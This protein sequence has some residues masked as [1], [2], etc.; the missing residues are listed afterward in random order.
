MKSIGMIEMSSIAAGFNVADTMLKAG[1]ITLILA[2]S[3]CSGKY[4][5]LIGG[6]TSSVQSSVDAGIAAADGCLIAHFVIAIAFLGAVREPVRNRW[7]FDFG[8]IACGLVVP[9]AL[10][11]GGWRGIPLWWRLVDCS[12]GILGFIPLWFCRGWTLELERIGS[13]TGA[14]S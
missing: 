9:F 5:V 6:E 3:I 2:R 12:F 13:K 1:D 14:P 7:L 10:L 11:V 8:L 4:M